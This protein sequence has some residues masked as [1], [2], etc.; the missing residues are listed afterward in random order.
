MHYVKHREVKSCGYK[1]YRLTCVTVSWLNCHRQCNLATKMASDDG[2]EEF[3]YSALSHTWANTSQLNTTRLV[4]TSIE[5][6]PLK[7]P[8]KAKAVRTGRVFRKT[9]QQPTAWQQKIQQAQLPRGAKFVSSYVDFYVIVCPHLH[10]LALIYVQAEQSR[11]WIT[12][13]ACPQ[14][15]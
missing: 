1:G 15:N 3:Q 10:D 9:K 8:W 13:Y 4:L 12:C 2:S 5:P 6:D 7:T 14:L 11:N